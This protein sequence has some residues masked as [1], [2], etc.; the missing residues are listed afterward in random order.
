MWALD[1]RFFNIRVIDVYV[2]SCA[3]VCFFVLIFVDST[4][5]LAAG[6]IILSLIAD[7][8]YSIVSRPDDVFFIRRLTEE[9][10]N[11]FN[12]ED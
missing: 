7:L 10:I 6:F 3:L 4:K 12:E 11:Q 8:Y 5:Y 1:M 2:L 9:E